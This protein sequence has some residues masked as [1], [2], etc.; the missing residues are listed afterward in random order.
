VPAGRGARSILDTLVR[1][2]DAHTAPA[3]EAD[4][5]QAALVLTVLPAGTGDPGTT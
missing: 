2:V 3:A 1:R 4:D 5:D